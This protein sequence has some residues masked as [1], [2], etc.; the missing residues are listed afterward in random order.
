LEWP[1]NSPDLNPIENLWGI[2]KRKV[3]QRRPET[4]EEL[5]AASKSEWSLIPLS[6]V[7]ACIDSMSKR[8]NSVTE[9]RDNKVDY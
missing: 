5:V 6:T 2:L 3:D 7:R 1:S 9:R 8:L 4:L